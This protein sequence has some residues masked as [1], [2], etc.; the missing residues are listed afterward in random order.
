MLD[1]PNDESKAEQM[2]RYMKNQFIFAGVQ[3]PQ[4]ALLQ[5]ELLK[6]ST[7]WTVEELMTVISDLYQK[8]EREYQYAAIDLA[9]KNVKRLE[10][11]ELKLFLSLTAQKKWWDS[12]DSWRKVYST[13]C[14]SHFDQLSA[15]YD[16]FYGQEDFW[17]RRIAITLQ[18]G[19]KEKTNQE[20]LKK[21]YQYDMYTNEFF[22]QKAIGWALRDYSKTNP[23][24]VKEQLGTETFSNLAV[25]EA[26][27]YLGESETTKK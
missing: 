18:L 27:K 2:A 10:M 12:I 23:V 9:L 22:I 13:W 24:W 1:F 14:L 8:P 3:K 21:A 4:R 26:S 16:W 19:F 7:K 6:D 17:M 15:V 11:E 20:L 5:K 25:R